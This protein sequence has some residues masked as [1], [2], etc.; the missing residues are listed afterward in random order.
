MDELYKPLPDVDAYLER[1]GIAAP[2]KPTQDFLDELIREH[3]RHVP[4]ENLDS[5]VFGSS[6]KSFTIA[7]K[8][9]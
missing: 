6:S 7:S 5:F 8:R 2:Q 3:Q 9:A 1:I 4:F